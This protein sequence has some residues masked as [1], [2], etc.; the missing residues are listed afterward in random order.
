MHEFLC[1]VYE[2]GKIWSSNPKVYDIKSD[3]ISGDTAK[4]GISR[5]ISQNILD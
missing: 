2:F 1:I 4:I 3:N 5:Q